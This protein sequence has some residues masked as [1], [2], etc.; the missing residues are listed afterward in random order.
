MADF[1][2]GVM[3]GNQNAP[4]YADILTGAVEAG[5]RGYGQKRFSQNLPGYKNFTQAS[6]DP[7][8]KYVYGDQGATDMQLEGLKASDTDAM[9]RMGYENALRVKQAGLD[10]PRLSVAKA[11]IEY[12][13]GTNMGMRGFTSRPAPQA[14]GKT[15]TDLLAEALQ[16]GAPANPLPTFDASLDTTV[17]GGES[18]NPGDVRQADQAAYKTLFDELKRQHPEASN[19]DVDYTVRLKLSGR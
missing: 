7:N 1:L 18:M 12:D 14:G 9:R 4:N 16:G 17:K 19:E 8:L 13:K 15:A 10:D 3:Y 11:L 2:R 6:Q 5:K